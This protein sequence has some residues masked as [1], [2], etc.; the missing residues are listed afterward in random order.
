MKVYIFIQSIQRELNVEY[1]PYININ[2]FN[3]NVT[4]WKQLCT[5]AE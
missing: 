4:L 5:F 2:K 3:L 1:I